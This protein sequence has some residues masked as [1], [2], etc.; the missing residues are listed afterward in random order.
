MSEE[1]KKSNLKTIQDSL[2]V[3]KAFGDQTVINETEK[4]EDAIKNLIAVNKPLI[5]DYA[6]EI[7][8]FDQGVVGKY[9]LQ[10][11]RVIEFGMIACITAKLFLF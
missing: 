7:K 6:K 1:I 2:I 11:A 9:G 4:I 5:E 8:T 10:V 3:L